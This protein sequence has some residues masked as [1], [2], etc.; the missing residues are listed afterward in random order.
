MKTGTNKTKQKPKYD[1]WQITAYMLGVAWRGRHWTVFTVGLSLALVTAGRTIAEL[2]FAPAVLRVLEQG[3]A[4]GR[5]LA[6]IGGFSVL[7]VAL[8]F[9]QSY[10][11]ERNLFGK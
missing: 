4:L 10:L 8:T 1:L 9:L 5:L 2:L 6:V 7:L 11:S 3:M